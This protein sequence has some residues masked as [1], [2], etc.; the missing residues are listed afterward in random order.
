MIQPDACPRV[1]G[2]RHHRIG[3]RQRHQLLA[4]VLRDDAAILLRHLVRDDDPV[5]LR[6][7]PAQP[8]D[9]LALRILRQRRPVLDVE[10]VDLVLAAVRL[11]QHRLGV[12]GRE[13]VG[14][15]DQPGHV[16]PASVQPAQQLEPLAVVP[17]HA[18]RDDVDPQR[19]QV[20]GDRAGR[21]G[22]GA[23]LDDLV[24]LQPGLQRDLGAAPVDQQIF[25]EKEVPDDEDGQFGKAGEQGVETFEIHGAVTIR[26]S[27][28]SV[29]RCGPRM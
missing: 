10:P 28:G 8:A 29:P 7:Q 21:A 19:A 25:V 2:E 11:A 22:A 13:A 6:H 1:R 18:H 14:P 24:R 16:H 17:H 26:Y 4:D 5:H 12:G 9:D 3:L 15:D 27:A 23:H 20:G